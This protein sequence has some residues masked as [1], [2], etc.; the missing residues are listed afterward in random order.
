MSATAIQLFEEDAGLAARLASIVAGG[1]VSSEHTRN[2][3]ADKSNVLVAGLF[4]GEPVGFISAHVIDR[5]KDYRRKVFIYEVDVLPAFQRRGVGRAM[6]QK[7]LEVGRS[8]GANTAFVL[9]NRSN[10]A[11]VTLYSASGGRETQPD[12]LMMEFPL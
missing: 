6:M 1:A 5:F 12:D 8:E 11:A 9:T 3:L 10:F 7:V 4:G 2:F